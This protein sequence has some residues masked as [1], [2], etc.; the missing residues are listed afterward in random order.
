MSTSSVSPRRTQYV[1]H[2]VQVLLGFLGAPV[3]L[4]VI[5]A[6]IFLLCQ[7]TWP[8]ICE[9]WA[10]APGTTK[11]IV[12]LGVN[13]LLLLTALL[14]WRKRRPIAIGILVFAVLDTLHLIYVVTS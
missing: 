13:T 7:T 8:G 10:G 6:I 5:A 4:L 14:F 1:G 11:I 12:V 3:S 2:V 9:S